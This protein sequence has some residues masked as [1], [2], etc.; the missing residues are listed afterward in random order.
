MQ[1]MGTL[2]ANQNHEYVQ[3]Y[4]YFDVIGRLE[5]RTKAG[6]AMLLHSHFAQVTCNRSPGLHFNIF[7]YIDNEN[8]SINNSTQMKEFMLM[9]GW[10]NCNA[11]HLL[12]IASHEVWWVVYKAMIELGLIRVSKGTLRVMFPVEGRFLPIP[13]AHVALLSRIKKDSNTSKAVLEALAQLPSKMRTN[14]EELP[15][16]DLINEFIKLKTENLTPTKSN[17]VYKLLMEEIKL[18]NPHQ[19]GKNPEKKRENFLEKISEKIVE[20]NIEKNPEINSENNNPENIPEIITTNIAEKIIQLKPEKNKMESNVLPVDEIHNF[21]R[22]DIKPRKKR[23]PITSI[24]APE[25]QSDDYK[26]DYKI[27]LEDTIFYAEETT[28]K[29]L[30]K[31]QE[32]IPETKPE[33]EIE[34]FAPSDMDDEIIEEL[35]ESAYDMFGLEIESDLND[36]DNDLVISIPEIPEPVK[37]TVQTP[38][39]SFWD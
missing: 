1:M 26:I 24:S 28:G 18:N 10:M 27:S 15:K 4:R 38:D 39:D 7:M 35:P 20:K 22:S 16:E 23:D 25:N 5:G 33:N 13:Y 34:K 30:K 32:S 36:N 37:K 31:I 21:E 29:D 14:L 6:Y 17:P 12:K 11:A 2:Q 19:W 9:D 3:L 8:G